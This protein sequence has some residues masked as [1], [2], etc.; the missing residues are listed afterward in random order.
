MQVHNPLSREYSVKGLKGAQ[1]TG[2]LELMAEGNR[3]PTMLDSVAEN[4]KQA[5]SDT[6]F[7]VAS[8]HY[9][10]C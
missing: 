10:P 3:M 8:F 2:S 6:R 9:Q 4:Y 1:E 5:C 7:S